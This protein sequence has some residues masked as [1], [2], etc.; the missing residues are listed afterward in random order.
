MV[1]LTLGINLEKPF[2]DYA[3][4]CI[5]SSYLQSSN[6]VKLCMGIEPSFY[7]DTKDTGPYCFNPCGHM[8]TENTVKYWSRIGIPLGTNG[9]ESFCPFCA[10]QL[11]GHP[12]YV[13]LIFN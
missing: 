10:T 2:T 11:E 12:G 1:F 8:A 4:T 3:N 6:V 5:F 13:K 9:F 7:V